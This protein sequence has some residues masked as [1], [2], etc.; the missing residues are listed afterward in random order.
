MNKVLVVTYHFPPDAA[1]GGLRWQK[2]VKYLPQFGWAP[3]VLTAQERYCETRD[4]WRLR[5]VGHAPIQRTRLLP[6]LRAVALSL[7]TCLL[8]IAP[9]RRGRPPSG[10]A[11]TSQ[12]WRTRGHTVSRA[13]RWLFSLFWLPDGYVGWLL[14]AV[15]RG[16]RM[17]RR[18]RFGVMVSSGPPHTCHLVGLILKGL[19]R[20]RWVADFR[21]P[22]VS[23]PHRPWSARSALSDVLNTV[24]ERAVIRA[25]DRV[26]VVTDR[27][28]RR[29]RQEYPGQPPEKF[30][31]ITNG[32][33]PEDFPIAMARSRKGGDRPFTL[34]HAGTIYGR[35][36]A[37][38]LL[39]GIA[40]LL[41]EPRVARSD[42]RLVFLGAIDDGKEFDAAVKALGL[43]DVVA[44][45]G[46][47]SYPDTVSLLYESDVL[48]LLAQDQP[49]QIPA[50]AFDYIAVGG[51]ILAVA[52]PGAT[53]DLV[54]QVG[55][56]VVADVAAEIASVCRDAY[57][58]S[59]SGSGRCRRHPSS[60]LAAQGAFDRR[61]LTARLG[62]LLDDKA[63]R[64]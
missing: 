8:A 34:T 61:V 40:Q 13:R 2:F 50:K 24:M 41:E 9:L 32:F 21:D 7:R 55:G 48:V 54:Q 4:P 39:K 53:A 29:F 62:A 27:L 46:R 23:N 33:D 37:T 28:A 3:H 38:A 22:W 52:G 14:P 18:E 42:V 49:D 63:G 10:V 20:T 64:A 47:L 57:T 26:I 15:V 56:R 16:V 17:C 19:T 1:V 60:D 31:T 6:N 36:S 30:V 59:R 51:E 44:C 45:R 11:Q 5:D 35:R 25:A 12:A 58:A 43:G